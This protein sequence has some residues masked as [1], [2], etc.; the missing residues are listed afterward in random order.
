MSNTDD[1][2]ID[3]ELTC[4]YCQSEFGKGGGISVKGEDY[5]LNVCMNCLN[6]LGDQ[7]D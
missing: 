1:G 7:N 3:L 2:G 6:S 4:E 5:I